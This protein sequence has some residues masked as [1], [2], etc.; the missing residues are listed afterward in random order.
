[1]TTEERHRRIG[2][3]LRQREHMSV[4]ELMAECGASGATIRRDLDAL[5]LR[6]VL[7]R[8]HGGARSLVSRG[9]NP[10]YGQRALEDH[11]AKV[12]IAAGVAALLQDRGHVWLDSGTTATEVARQLRD[13][14]LT[15][16]PMSL[17]AVNAMTSASPRLRPELLLPGGSLTPGELSF[18][19]PLTESNIRA[20][21]FDAAVLTP[22]AVNLRDGLLAHDL[23]D[24]AVKRAGLESAARVIAACS[25]AKWDATAVALV[26]G[27]DAVDILVTDKDLGPAERA[28]LARHSVEAVI[29]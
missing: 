26:A 8:V 21:R 25:E 6:G 16:M 12:R 1:M 3:L 14:D 13:R 22:C 11:D 2:E 5:A 18:R 17:Q 15:V 20:L 24:A 28:E 4:D 23:A 10:E 29:V 7:R 27:L 19:G 9:E